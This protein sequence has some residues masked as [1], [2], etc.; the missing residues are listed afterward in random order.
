VNA[1]DI[2]CATVC[3]PAAGTVPCCPEDPTDPNAIKYCTQKLGV[4]ATCQSNVCTKCGAASNFNYVVDP[5]NGDDSIG[6]GASTAGCAL[7]TITRALQVIPPNP[8]LPVTITVLGA[9]TVKESNGEKFPITIPKGVTITTSGG[10]VTVNVPTI[11]FAMGAPNSALMGAAP[12]SLVIS[13]INSTGSNGIVASLGSDATTQI[14][15]LDV[16]G[17]ADDGIRVQGTSVLSIGS[18]VS[19][20]KNGTATGSRSGLHV[21]DGHA[22]I[23][24]AANTVTR[25]DENTRHGIEVDGSGFVTLTGT[26]TDAVAGTGTVVVRANDNA[27]LWIAQTGN[28]PPQNVV[29]GL[30]SFASPHGPAGIEI[31]AGSNLKLRSSV[32]L[33]NAQAGVRV[34]VGSG[35]STDAGAAAS[36]DISMIDL[37][38]AA[39]DGKNVFQASLGMNPNGGAGIC[40]SMK[41]NLGATLSARGNVFEANNCATTAAPLTANKVD[42]ISLSGVLDLGFE[43]V[44]IPDGGV[45]NAIDVLKCTHP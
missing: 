24:P 28:N 27:G 16:T 43:T 5:N 8:L 2:C 15:N 30:V 10:T 4:G 45:P 25:F 42:C 17:F 19:S 32:S 44:G 18:W 40:L 34:E 12:S 1:S 35:S 14:A 29:S 7:K 37:G 13:G 20:T 11:G 6:T 26:V 9:S 23:N 38:S 33:A 22:I 31:L 36:N 21:T 41:A 3:A 39:E